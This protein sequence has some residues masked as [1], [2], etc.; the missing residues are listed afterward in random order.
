VSTLPTADP[1]ATPEAEAKAKTMPIV[2]DPEGGRPM[3][4]DALGKLAAKA[5][6]VP[7]ES[8]ADMTAELAAES[9]LK[10][11]LAQLDK[12]VRQILAGAAKPDAAGQAESD[13]PPVDTQPAP[14]AKPHM[15]T[16]KE[17]GPQPA[18]DAKPAHHADAR[19]QAAAMGLTELHAHDVKGNTPVDL[20]AA[21]IQSAPSTNVAAQAHSAP[22][23]A[24][25]PVVVPL[26][27]LAVAIAANA[28][29]GRNHFEIRLDP[30][31]LGRIDVRL[32]IDSTGQVTSHL[33]ADR[34][35]TLDM[36]RRDAA[37][38]ERSLQQA[39]LKTSDQALQFSLRDQSRGTEGDG[40]QHAPR[41]HVIVPDT[42]ATTDI[43]MRGYTRA[44]QGA[45]LDIRV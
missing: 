14:D 27:G 21:A 15:P 40:G 19:A 7:T 26:G 5:D 9:P 35:D 3:E 24:A 13:A 23:Q 29:N 45:G 30:P 6:G 39:G 41:A 16:P 38:L 11:M 32:H 33:I 17:D 42:E 18:P 8:D 34:S 4:L 22:A 10:P 43:V 28:Q 1:L 25:P 2:P 12:P 44:G 20:A 31:E 36:L 37:D